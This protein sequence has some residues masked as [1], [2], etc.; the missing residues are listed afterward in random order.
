MTDTFGLDENVQEHQVPQS[1][2]Q[3][4]ITA[5]SDYAGNRPQTNNQPEL[6]VNFR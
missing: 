3:G 5:L 1:V 4:V 6:F 2:I